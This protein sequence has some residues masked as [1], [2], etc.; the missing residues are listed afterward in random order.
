MSNFETIIYKN[1]GAQ[2]VVSN[3]IGGDNYQRIVIIV[4]NTSLKLK[5]GKNFKDEL[6]KK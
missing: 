4:A 5:I 1:T 6:N 2:E 3:I